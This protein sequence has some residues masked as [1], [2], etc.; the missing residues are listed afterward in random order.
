MNTL[1]FS[2]NQTQ[3]QPQA[4]ENVV[5]VVNNEPV[6][7]KVK[8]EPPELVD[9]AISPIDQSSEKKESKKRKR[10]PKAPLPAK[11]TPTIQNARQTKHL[12]YCVAELKEFLKA[13]Q[14]KVSGN[15]KELHDRL[16][17]HLLLTGK[18]IRAQ[19]VFRGWLVRSVYRLFN[20]YQTMVADC[21]NDQDFYS[22]EPLNEINKFQLICVKEQKGNGD[23]DGPVYGFD[24]SSIYQYKKK[25][26]IGT[27]LTN[28]YNRN[29]FPPSFFAELSKIACSAKMGFLPTVLDI[30]PDM[31]TN[32]LSFEKKVEL[33]ALAL[34]QHINALGN[35]SDASWFLQLSR[36]RVIDMIQELYDIWR[37]RLN[38]NEATK[39][40]I[41]PPHGNP[42]GSLIHVNIRAMSDT[43]LK[44]LVLEVFENFVYRGVDRDAQCLGA[45]YILGALTIV[46]SVAADASP[47]L[48][49]SFVY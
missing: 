23:S 46:S 32:G 25:L 45:F 21:V 13:N 33:K 19:A 22:F 11:E 43:E 18:L 2:A 12:N 1:Q 35:Y 20:K 42:F 38:I 36:R 49:Q 30:E 27:N 31:E 39:R 41:C 7:I 15:K 16:F 37:H 47:W 10:E 24:I 26:E 8:I 6:N 17:G 28:P 48:Y 40:S 34:F 14:L 3:T 5:I 44:N 4:Y 9:N 29:E